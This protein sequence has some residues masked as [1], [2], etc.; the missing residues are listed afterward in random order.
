MEDEISQFA[1]TNGG[2]HV[3]KIWGSTLYHLDD[4][5]YESISQ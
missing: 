3:Q 2:L 5:P 1:Q 4:M